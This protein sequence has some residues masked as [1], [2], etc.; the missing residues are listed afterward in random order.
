MRF[1]AR[2]PQRHIDRKPFPAKFGLG[3]L[4]VFLCFFTGVCGLTGPVLAADEAFDIALHATERPF[5]E[6]AAATD[7]G[8][9]SLSAKHVEFLGYLSRMLQPDQA[10][11]DNPLLRS[12]RLAGDSRIDIA[13]GAQLPLGLAVTL[14]EWGSGQRDLRV[15]AETALSLEDMTLGHR[16]TVTTQFAA[17]GGQIHQTA[18][19]LRLG[20]TGLGGVQEGIVEYDTAPS[21]QVTLFSLRSEWTFDSGS[22]ADSASAARVA[23]T[24]R[25]LDGVSEAR[26]GY[27]QPLGPFQWT[28]DLAADSAGAYA[29]GLSLALPLGPEPEPMS[30]SLGDL[31]A[32][33]GGAADV[34]SVGPAFTPN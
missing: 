15:I 5:G 9:I 29:V 32:A 19:R 25:P 33:L 8:G 22:A 20:I 13:P 23:L 21:P 31:L 3:S 16:L 10:G 24:H 27:R 17:D 1:L 26:F 4:A 18:G 34:G 30:W 7:L 2:A 6:I 28:S 14:D 11:E 12:S